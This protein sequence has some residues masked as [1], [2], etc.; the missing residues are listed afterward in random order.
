MMLP[1]N[2]LE[3]IML[4]NV[5]IIGPDGVGKSTLLSEIGNS[6]PVKSTSGYLGIGKEGWVFASAQRLSKKRKS[7]VS[8]ALF[9]YLVL[10]V[11]LSIRRL[12]IL[13]KGRGGVILI[14][15]VPGKPLLGNIVLRLLYRTLLPC[16]CMVVLLTG[17]PK[18]VAARKPDETTPERTE[19]EIA[20]WERVA[21]SLGAESILEIDTTLHDI[22]TCSNLVVEAILTD[23]CI[24]AALYRKSP[25]G[26]GK[27]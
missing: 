19:R 18:Q 8:S 20:K 25:P 14:D 12:L 1:K 15:R 5:I 16:P 24:R 23:S 2:I 6:L 11:E 10:P 13:L 26:G 7:R 22:N 17:D 9:W 4:A 27:A 21:N 3:K